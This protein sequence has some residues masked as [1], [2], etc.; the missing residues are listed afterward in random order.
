MPDR[1]T[2]D[3]IA[4]LHRQH[5]FAERT[6]GPGLRDAALAAHVRKELDEVAEAAD[7]GDSLRTAEEWVDVITLASEAALRRL[8]HAGRGNA[9]MALATLLAAKQAENEQRRWPDW[10]KADPGQ[11]IEHDR[12][13][14]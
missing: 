8:E 14:E 13:A 3:L 12:S 2:F 1:P 11:P 5:A 10:R 6:F 4:H 9:A 7:S